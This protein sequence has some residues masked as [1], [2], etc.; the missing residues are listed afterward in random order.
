MPEITLAD[1]LSCAR[2][3]LRLRREL[4]P[5]YIVRHKMTPAFAAF[6]LACQE[7]I[8]RR[9]EQVLIEEIVEEHLPTKER[10]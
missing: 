4:Y 10:L 3:E 7:A 6:Q 1:E 8:V 2:R 9:L 5:G